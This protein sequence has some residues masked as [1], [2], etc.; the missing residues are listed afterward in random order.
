MTM[1]EM[2]V[3]APGQIVETLG[4][5][6]VRRHK[7]QPLHDEGVAEDD[8]DDRHAPDGDSAP[9]SRPGDQSG[10]DDDQENEA[11]TDATVF[12]PPM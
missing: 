11:A 3:K 1:A 5:P 9:R 6:K 7:G 12:L 2:K 10:H 8:S 4:L